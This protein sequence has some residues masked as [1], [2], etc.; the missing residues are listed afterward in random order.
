MTLHYLDKPSTAETIFSFL[1]DEIKDWFTSRFPAGFTPPQLYSIPLIHEQKNTLIFS[2][3]GSGKTF[4]AFLAAINELYI[5]STKGNLKDQIYVLYISP[6]KALGNDIRKNLE[7]PLQGIQDLAAANNIVVPKI[8]VDVRTGDTPQS[9][10]VKMLKHPPHI[11]ITTPESLGLIMTSPKFSQHLKSVRWVI[12]DEIHEVSSNKR[13]VFLSLC[14]EFLQ[15]QLAEKKLTKIGLSATQAPIEEIAR[16]LVGRD[17]NGVENDCY[18]ANLPPQRKLDLEVISPVK[19]LLHTPYVMV[20][21]GIYSVLSDLTLDHETSIIFT[22]TRKGAESVAFKLKEFLGDEYAPLIAVHHSSLS[23]EIRLDVEDR[24]KNNELVAAVTSTSLELGIDIG[25]VE[26]VSQIGSPKTVAKYL[27]RVGRSGHALD[28]IARGRLLVTGRDDAIECAVLTKS[29]Y[30]HVLDKVQ[31]PQNCLDVLAQFIVG[32][33]LT[34]RWN[35]D[36]AYTMIKRSYNYRDLSFIDYI[37]VLEYLGGY[38]LDIEEQKVYRKIWYDHKEKAFGKKRNSRLIFYTN[39]GTIPENSNFRVE[40]ETYRTRIGVLSEKFVERLTP[41]DVFVLGS[42]SYQFKRTVG[43]RVVVSESFG[44]RPTIPNWVGEELPRS[45]ELSQQIGKFIDIVAQRI[46]K[47]KTKDTVEWI[48]ASFKV[49]EIIAK[50]IVDYVKEQQLFL[51]I[52]PNE[53]SLLIESFLDPQGRMTIVFHAYFGRRVNDAFARALAFSIG[54]DIDADV[55][56][57][58]N[59]NGFLLMLP[60]GKIYD[61]SI[62]PTLL[63]SDNLEN[64]VKQAIINTELFQTRFRHV[65]NRAFMILRRSGNKYIPVSRQTMYARRLFPT[66]KTQESFCIIKETYREILRDYMDLENAHNVV[67]KLEKGEYTYKI[68]PLADIPS[69][70]AHGIVL[71]GVADIVQISDRSALL[72]ELHQQVLSKVF[73]KEGTKEILFRKDL[74]D[75]IFNNRSYRNDE[76][77]ISSL[78][79]LRRAIKAISPIRTI[80][81]IP[82]SIYH[83]CISDPKQ[84]KSWVFALHNNKELME[85]HISQTERRTILLEDFPLYWNIYLKSIELS[86][87]DGQ[88]LELIKEKHPISLAKITEELELQDQDIKL[89]LERLERVMLITR[90][91]FETYKGKT[92]WKYIS[93][94]DFVPESFR[95]KAKKLDPEVCLEK[96][97]L[98]YLKIN[99]PSSASDIVEYL[100]LDQEKISR[101]LIELEQKNRVLKGQIIASTLE[102]QYIRLEDRELLRNLSNRKPDSLLLTSEELNFIHYYFTV[103]AY[104]K[105][106]LT[107]KESILFLLDDFGSI[108]DLSSLAFRIKDYDIDWVREHIEKNDIIQGRFGH[109]R[110]AYVS[111][112]HFPY[113]YIAYRETFELSKV[114]EKILSTLQRYGPLTR[115]ELVEYVDLDQDIIQESIMILD[116]TLHL[117]RKSVAIDSFLPKQFV[118]NVYDISSRYFTLEKLPN[119]EQSIQFILNKLI[120]SLGPVSL[121]E[122]THISGFKYSDVEKNIRDLIKQ[123]KIFE[124]KLTARE[125]NYYLTPK[126]F[127]T[128]FKLKADFIYLSLHEDEKTLILP[129][130]DPFTKLGLR[131]HIRDVYG[132]GKIDPILLD[133]EIVGSVEYKLHRGKYLQ[134]YNLQLDD[135][136][137]YN[138]LLLQ[139][140]ASELVSYTRKIHRVLSLQIEDVNRKSILSA[141]NKFIKD[142]LIKTGFILIQDTLVGGDTITRIFSRSIADKY[143][144]DKVWLR[145]DSPALNETSLL[146]LINHFGVLSFEA[147]NARFPETMHAIIIFLINKLLEEKKILCQDNKLYSLTFARY[148]KSGL[149]RRRKLKIEHEELLKLITKGISNIQDLS[150]KWTGASTALKPS[151]RLL[152]TNMLVGVKSISNSYQPQEYWDISKF[153]PEFD[154]DLTVIKRRYVRDI[155]YSLGLSSENQIIER[156]S[157]P[158]ILTKIKIKEILSNLIEE[159]EI[160]GGRFIEDDLNFYY[161]TSENYDELIMHEKQFEASKDYSSEKDKGRFYVL[162]P[163]DVAHSLLRNNLPERF[164]ISGDNYLILLNQKLAAQCK[165]ES[166][167]YKQ[168]SVKNLNI[169]PW[170]QNEGAFNY[171]INALETISPSH[172]SSTPIVTIKKINGINTYAL[173]D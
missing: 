30:A 85:I 4:A 15:T 157:I 8:R 128:I 21:E 65:A 91:N 116:K 97:V 111:R 22:N 134:I 16:F 50:T 51:N 71:L 101:T 14:L 169:A 99:G 2:S 41:G 152:E 139:K 56:S 12:L 86:E 5:E 72:R 143:V 131:L 165:I 39:L 38:N 121:I 122:L 126:R 57:A 76:L 58:V 37:N 42:H 163:T 113:Y 149:R 66:L 102:P 20:Q 81:S 109:N 53:K 114:E 46:Q 3:T 138:F 130:S 137:A 132:E 74:V 18:I 153:I 129:R 36:E 108:E 70:F 68:A 90:I 123:K 87:K 151:L 69:P 52:T 146:S 103:D 144:M 19:D 61:T 63:T 161:I 119:Y 67:K 1:A 27:Q 6:L 145:K 55:A 49:D 25:S 162:H 100:L 127:E 107:G 160:F 112:E 11:L 54:R 120:E 78:K 48:Q 150:H 31:I 98:K 64:L 154:D 7:E 159:E 79:H 88:V 166:H 89:N 95:A 106:A 84:I 136:V 77:P 93:I 118:P 117:V 80:E 94:E 10:R 45:F 35:V 92:T 75:S 173:V 73:G 59:D 147:I 171:I 104:F 24:L 168:L 26:L 62:I 170:V 125:T 23:R 140:I 156:A 105:Q 124:K 34:K 158:S 135:I 110:L 9:Q 133:G 148:R 164:D 142:S 44:R 29:A 115:R 43:S 47:E 167:D 83:R 33:S 172:D 60:A 82:P 155:V 40:L 32:I 17:D 96:I 13:G 141:T 28:R